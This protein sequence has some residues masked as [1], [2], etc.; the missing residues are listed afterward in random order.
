MDNTKYVIK[1]VVEEQMHTK[2]G[3]I[4]ALGKG[5]SG[6]VYS[7]EIACEPYIIAVKMSDYY[8][9]MCRADLHFV[10]AISGCRI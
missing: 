4:C 7:V 10:T 9:A 8:D 6:C 3:R 5:A 2:A 1:S